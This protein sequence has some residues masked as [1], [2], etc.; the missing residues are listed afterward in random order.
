MQALMS[1]YERKFPKLYELNKNIDNFPSLLENI[2]K[3]YQYT[4]R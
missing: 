1:I 4:D 3:I 2:A